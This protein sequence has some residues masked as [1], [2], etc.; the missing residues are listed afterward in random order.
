MS[1]L[2]VCDEL[3]ALLEPDPT[4]RSD[5]RRR[6]TH[7]NPV[8]AGRL[9]LWPERVRYDL[10]SQGFEDEERFVIAIAWATPLEDEQAGARAIEARWTA[11]RDAIAAVAGNGRS[12]EH[13][14]VGDVDPDGL[15]Q[16]DSWGF[17]ALIDG[18][19]IRGRE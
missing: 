17:V 12:F 7:D 2:D 16:L 8:V 3:A 13:A 9:Y 15:V 19:H 6:P 18:Y 10:V 4:L 5:T 11:A 1:V 14:H